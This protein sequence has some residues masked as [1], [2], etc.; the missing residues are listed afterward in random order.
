MGEVRHENKSKHF[1]MET[2]PVLPGH[3]QNFSEINQQQTE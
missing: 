3:R 2:N 1:P